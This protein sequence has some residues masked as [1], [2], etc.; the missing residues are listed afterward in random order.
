MAPSMSPNATPSS[1]RGGVR[2]IP[3]HCRRPT[4]GVPRDP[5]V[6]AIPFDWKSSSASLHT[7]NPAAERYPRACNATA[8]DSRHQRERQVLLACILKLSGTA[9]APP[10]AALPC[11]DRPTAV[12]RLCSGRRPPV[13]CPAPAGPS[14][15][16]CLLLAHSR[17]RV[18]SSAPQ[19]SAGLQRRRPAARRQDALT[20][21]RPGLRK[22]RLSST[23]GGSSHSSFAAAVDE[24][25]R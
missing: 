17:C 7:S 4:H 9:A 12:R 21:A 5:A 13:R 14:I 25:A 6:V 15:A 16:R 22:P 24:V 18:E 3:S 8:I 10:C 1:V 19:L 20:R 2:A 23:Q 11:P